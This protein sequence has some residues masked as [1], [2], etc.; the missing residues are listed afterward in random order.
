[1]KDELLLKALGKSYF[2]SLLSD[3]GTSRILDQLKVINLFPSF[4]TD[5]HKLS[6][7]SSVTLEEIEVALKGFKKDKIS[8]LD[9]CPIEFFLWYFKL[10]G[11]DL[12]KVV[13]QSKIDVKVP[14]SL[15]ST[16]LTLIP[17]C[18]KPQ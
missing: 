6:F 16:F 8:G 10:V 17:K 7:C 4:L 5:E 12:L 1:M 15:N 2:S 18:E 9:G 11:G 3:D 13:E 14:S